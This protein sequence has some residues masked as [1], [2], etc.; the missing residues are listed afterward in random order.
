MANKLDEFGATITT[1]NQCDIVMII[2]SRI[3]PN[4]SNDLIGIPG[5]LSIRAQ[6]RF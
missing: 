3:L 5:F 6:G 2:E 1:V 4:I